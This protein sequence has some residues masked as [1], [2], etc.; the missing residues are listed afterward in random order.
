MPP[1]GCTYDRLCLWELSPEHFSGMLDPCYSRCFQIFLGDAN[2]VS[3]KSFRLSGGHMWY[4][5]LRTFGSSVRLFSS[6][7]YHCNSLDQGTLVFL[8][9]LPWPLIKTFSH[10]RQFLVCLIGYVRINTL[11]SNESVQS[12]IRQWPP[13]ILHSCPNSTPLRCQ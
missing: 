10:P 3:H 1:Q 4:R 7:S 5:R 2:Q 6:S 8:H 9:E 13:Q 12:L 11:L